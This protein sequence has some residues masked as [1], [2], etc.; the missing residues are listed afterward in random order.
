[1]HPSRRMPGRWIGPELWPTLNELAAGLLPAA[2]SSE[3]L[4]A[5][6]ELS[7]MLLEWLTWLSMPLG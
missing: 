4:P 1:M 7:T 2:A 5:F 3:G 6:E